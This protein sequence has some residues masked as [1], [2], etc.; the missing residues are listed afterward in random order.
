[1]TRQRIHE[2]PKK[3]VTDEALKPVAVQIDYAD[4]LEIERWLELRSDA[5]DGPITDLLEYSGVIPLTEDPLVYQA[6]MRGEWS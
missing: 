3:I 6:R 1:M 2:I 4:W 5:V